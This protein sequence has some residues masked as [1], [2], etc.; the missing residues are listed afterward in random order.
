MKVE[1]KEILKKTVRLCK[2]AFIAYFILV[3][4]ALILHVKEELQGW[5]SIIFMIVSLSCWIRIEKVIKSE[6]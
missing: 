1:N 2:F 3:I 4:L 6:N 5:I